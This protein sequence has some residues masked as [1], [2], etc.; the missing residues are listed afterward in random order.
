MIIIVTL[1][2]DERY[3]LDVGFGSDSPTRPLPLIPGAVTRGI[4]LQERRLVRENIAQNPDCDQQLWI[5]QRRH[6]P[7][8]EWISMYCFTASEFLPE[9]YEMT[10]F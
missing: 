7:Q 1:L 9:N 2:D 3:M 4:E 5:Y 6:S 10:S 8:E